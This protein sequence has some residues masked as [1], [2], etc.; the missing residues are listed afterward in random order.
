MGQDLK[1]SFVREQSKKKMKVFK[2]TKND[3]KKITFLSFSIF[4]TLVL[5]ISITLVIM[6]FVASY[7]TFLKSVPIFITI[8]SFA[9]ILTLLFVCVIFYLYYKSLENSQTND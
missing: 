8:L 4:L 1:H 6:R 7:E 5:C 2:F 3:A 9:L